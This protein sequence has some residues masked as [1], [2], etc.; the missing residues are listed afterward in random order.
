MTEAEWEWLARKS[1]REMQT[2]FPWGN[3]AVIP[4]KWGNVADESAKGT[5]QFYVPNYNDGFVKTA[6]VGSFKA[7]T[8]GLFDLVGNVS[9]WVHDYYALV[10]TDFKNVFEDPVGP[11][12]GHTRVVKGSSWRSGTRTS[13]RAAYRNGLSNGQDDVGFRIGRYLSRSQ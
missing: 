9:E 4:T 5:T 6:P 3:D 8:S 7:E 12:S 2:V 1:G 13:L 11:P 10:P